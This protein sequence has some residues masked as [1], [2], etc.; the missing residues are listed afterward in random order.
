MTRAETVTLF[1][2]LCILAPGG[3]IDAAIRWEAIDDHSA[4]GHFTHGANTVAATLVFNDAGEL[5]DFV[6]DDRLRSSADG[7]SFLSQRW[8]T[9][10][11]DYRTFGAT[12]LATR[13]EGLWHAPAPEGRFAYLTY[14]LFEIEY[15]VQKHEP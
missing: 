6:S 12:R 5:V 2:D 1:N 7:K 4:R 3:L 14:E 9:P 13:G 11:R 10:L 8:S 15:N